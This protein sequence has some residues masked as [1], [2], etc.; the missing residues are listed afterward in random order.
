MLELLNEP[1]DGA[2]PAAMGARVAAKVHVCAGTNGHQ[3][4]P[5][6]NATPKGVLRGPATSPS[7]FPAPSAPVS[8]CPPQAG[9]VA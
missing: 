6:A 5:M 1:H 3:P 8:M 4:V 2:L 7:G 9:G